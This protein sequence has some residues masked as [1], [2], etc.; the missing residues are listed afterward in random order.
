MI[1][2]VSI[3]AGLLVAAL[4]F[5]VFFDDWGGFWECVRYYLTPDVISL[6]RGEWGADQWATMKLGIYTALSVG[7]GYLAFVKLHQLFG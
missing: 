1:L 3:G 4:L 6:F 5:R 2:A 7:S